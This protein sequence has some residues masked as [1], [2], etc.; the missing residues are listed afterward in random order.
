MG[1]SF[2]EYIESIKSQ[3]PML[4]YEMSEQIIKV[5]DYN[6]IAELY[7]EEQYTLNDDEYIVLCNYD[8]MEDIRNQL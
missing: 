6:K 5:S 8:Q 2:G 1:Y 7:G 3:Y 4:S